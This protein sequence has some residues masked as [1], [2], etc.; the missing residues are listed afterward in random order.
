M[1]AGINYLGLN[2]TLQ[3]TPMTMGSYQSFKPVYFIWD[4][5]DYE[6]P[7]NSVNNNPSRNP[8]MKINSYRIVE[9][10]SPSEINDYQRINNPYMQ[11]QLDFG[12]KNIT[13]GVY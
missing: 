7:D 6:L 2:P 8:R 3:T 1:T 10:F 11:N 12:N 9:P 4:G 13:G 5:G